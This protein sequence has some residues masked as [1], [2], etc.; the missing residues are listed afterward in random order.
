MV[1]VPTVRIVADYCSPGYRLA[2]DEARALGTL[3]VDDTLLA[4][5]AAWSDRYDERC[6]P[7]AY[8]DVTGK[9]FDFIAFARD[10]LAIA[11]AVKRALPGWTV[12]YWDDSLDWFLARDPRGYNPR[13]CEYEITLADAVK[14]ED[15]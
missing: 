6:D 1:S 12:L 15:E 4:R 5:L 3:P 7:A 10:G 11:R 9:R 14:T 13:L 2:D 8:E